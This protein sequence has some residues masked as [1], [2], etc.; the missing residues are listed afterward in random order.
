[1]RIRLPQLHDKLLRTL[2][3]ALITYGFAATCVAETVEG[4][5][6]PFRTIKVASAE[7]GI[8]ARVF[9]EEGA[10]VSAGQQLVTLDDEVHRML[11][12]IARK[13]MDAT[14]RIN[15]TRAE[16]ELNRSRFAKLLELRQAGQAYQQEVDRARADVDVAEG[17]LLAIEEELALRRLEYKK[18]EVQLG[19]RTVTAPVSGVVTTLTKFPGEYV[20]PVDPE[21]ATLVQ[22]NPLRATFLMSR[23]QSMKLRVGS[24]A[25]VTFVDSNLSAQGVVEQVSALTDAESGTV[26]VRIR[27]DNHEGRYRSGERCTMEVN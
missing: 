17:R 12:E 13:Q 18:I 21:V 22:L 4:F 16:V 14:G 24:S 11:L 26:P 9:V 8:V 23:N 5:S 20:S 6:E 1:M 7:S 2:A 10:V 27:I 3:A 19:R 25:T 15:S